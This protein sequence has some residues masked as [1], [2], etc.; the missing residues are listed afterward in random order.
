VRET[1][2]GAVWEN[3]GQYTCCSHNDTV[4]I[5]MWHG[6]G[7]HSSECHSSNFQNQSHRSTPRSTNNQKL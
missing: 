6:T 1:S 4:S 7:M 5:S 3:L 2:Y